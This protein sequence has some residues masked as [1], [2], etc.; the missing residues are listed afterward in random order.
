LRNA[1]A[2]SGYR[3]DFD[4]EKETLSGSTQRAKVRPPSRLARAMRTI[5]AR[6][7]LH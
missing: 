2:A 7:R 1:H 5:D 3:A 4:V 6:I